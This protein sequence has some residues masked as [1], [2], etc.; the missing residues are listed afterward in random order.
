MNLKSI[1]PNLREMASARLHERN[2]EGFL[3]LVGHRERGELLAAN[4]GLLQAM[5]LFERGLVATYIH[6]PHWPS[7][8]WLEMFAACDRSKLEACGDS[9]RPTA[10]LTLFRGMRHAGHRG[11]IRG[12]SW[13][14]SPQI[15]AWFALRF[16]TD[17]D[18][19]AVYRLTVPP[20]R[21]LFLTN[22]R[23]EEEVIIDARGIPG[24]SR[25]KELPEPIRSI[26][27]P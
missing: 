11:W 12:L 24:L 3:G 22:E 5:G 6:G 15:A 4:R 18:S 27:A 1:N 8:T 26:G 9:P 23:Q 16:A 10:P 21:I 19:P 17:Q 20:E 2:V 7:R 13:T 25:L 14:T